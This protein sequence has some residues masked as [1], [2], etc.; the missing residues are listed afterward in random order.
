MNFIQAGRYNQK[1]NFLEEIF[2]YSIQKILNLF[3]YNGRKM[4]TQTKLLNFYVYLIRYG[5]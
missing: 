3:S 2:S 4:K 1:S 5:I